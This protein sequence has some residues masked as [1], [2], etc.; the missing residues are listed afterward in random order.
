MECAMNSLRNLF[1]PWGELARIMEHIVSRTDFVFECPL[2][3]FYLE[4]LF[5]VFV[6]K[7]RFYLAPSLRRTICET[8]FKA[9]TY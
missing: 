4:L 1:V 8:Q 6:C 7:V 5:I 2:R 3:G 9:I